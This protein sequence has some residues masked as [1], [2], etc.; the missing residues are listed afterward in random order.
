MKKERGD[1]HRPLRSA[2]KAPGHFLLGVSFASALRRAKPQW[3]LPITTP[4]AL[5]SESDAE[6]RGWGWAHNASSLLGHIC[7]QIHHLEPIHSHHKAA[8]ALLNPRT[9]QQ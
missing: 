9:V 2:C 4:V 6:A 1:G 3:A 7:L 5:G 8:W